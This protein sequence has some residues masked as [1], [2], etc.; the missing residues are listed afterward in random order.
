MNLYEVVNTIESKFIILDLGFGTAL[1]F[2]SESASHNDNLRK[3]FIEGGSLS[4]SYH[5]MNQFVFSK[6]TED[7]IHY[8]DANENGVLLSLAKKELMEIIHRR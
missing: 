8:R 7:W 3:T 5:D 6:E 4:F 1:E 2:K